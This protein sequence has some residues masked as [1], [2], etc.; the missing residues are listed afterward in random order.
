MPTSIEI[1]LDAATSSPSNLESTYPKKNPDA[2]RR[3]EASTT[4]RPDVRIAEELWAIAFPQRTP[5]VATAMGGIKGET[6]LT[7]PWKYWFRKAPA[8][9]GRRTTCT[10]HIVASDNLSKQQ[11]LLRSGGKLRNVT[12]SVENNIPAAST[13]TYWPASLAVRKGVMIYNMNGYKT[14]ENV[15]KK[16]GFEP[17]YLNIVLED[18]LIF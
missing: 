12:C 10:K 13:A 8:I 17:M 5:T 9:T 16:E 11:L 2:C 6:N 18:A 3:D 15:T 1:V 4:C 7:R 14:S